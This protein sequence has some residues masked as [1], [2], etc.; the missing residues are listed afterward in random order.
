M[1]YKIRIHNEGAITENKLLILFTWTLSIIPIR[2]KQI[3]EI[4]VIIIEKYKRAFP[5]II[6][7]SAPNEPKNRKTDIKNTLI[8]S[9]KFPINAIKLF[10]NKKSISFHIDVSRRK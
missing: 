10:F 9:T 4:V 7:C 5:F 8:P 1:I 6:P 2:K 3:S